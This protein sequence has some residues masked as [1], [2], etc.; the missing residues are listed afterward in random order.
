MGRLLRQSAR[1]FTLFHDNDH[2]EKNKI[3]LAQLVRAFPTSINV[4]EQYALIVFPTETTVCCQKKR[5]IMISFPVRS[6]SPEKRR[7][8]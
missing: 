6:G 5:E 3:G 7:K 1:L 2:T 8:I 4:S